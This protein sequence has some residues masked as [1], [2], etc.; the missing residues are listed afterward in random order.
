VEVAVV[1]EAVEVCQWVGEVDVT[2]RTRSR[3]PWLAAFTL[4]LAITL[5]GVLAAGGERR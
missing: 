4:V 5:T 1:A 3:G 2:A